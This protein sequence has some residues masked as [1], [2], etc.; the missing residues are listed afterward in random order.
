L[1]RLTARSG[2]NGPP[3]NSRRGQFNGCEARF[4]GYEARFDGSEAPFDA[5]EVDLGADDN[6]GAGRIEWQ[7]ERDREGRLGHMEKDRK[8][9]QIQIFLLS[10][11]ISALYYISIVFT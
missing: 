10:F 9:E 11:Y 4:V 3:I 2:C 5:Y 1:R 8:G 7:R 6:N